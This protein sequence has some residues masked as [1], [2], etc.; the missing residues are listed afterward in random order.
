MAGDN[1][2]ARRT[3]I[4]SGHSRVAFYGKCASIWEA[5]L[6][7]LRQIHAVETA[8][9]ESIPITACFADIGVWN[10]RHGTPRVTSLAGYRVHGGLVELIQQAH[11]RHRGFDVVVCT[12]ESRLPRRVSEHQAVLL[13]LVECG[14]RVVTLSS[15]IP[16]DFPGSAAST[17]HTWSSGLSDWATQEHD[18]MCHLPNGPTVVARG[19]VR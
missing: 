7:L 6:S 19:E 11:D 5:P 4:Q 3:T 16:P 15:V 13:E 17:L 18:P 10:R 8:L 9:S 14:V 1:S 12:D 2:P